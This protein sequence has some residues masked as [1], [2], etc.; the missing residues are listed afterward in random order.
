MKILALLRA[1]RYKQFRATVAP[2][3]E[4]QSV[5]LVTLKSRL[6]DSDA[7]LIVVDPSRM[8][9]E[10]F[11]AL[12]E[13]ANANGNT[14]VL[15]HAPL[16]PETAR[17]VVEASRIQC[18]EVVFFG[19][20][21]ER[22]AL[23]Q[24]CDQLMVPSVPALVLSGLAESLARMPPPLATRVVGQLGGQPFL[25]STS[26]MLNGLG[27]D[28]HTVRRWLTVAGITHPHHLRSSVVLARTF[29]ELARRRQSLAQIVDHFDAGSERGFRR[30]CKTLTRLPPR[31]AGRLDGVDFA[32]RMLS[33]VLDHRDSARTPRRESGRKRS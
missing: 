8:R 19:A 12:M 7:K 20:Y 11:I 28:S 15:V 9:P 24:V 25:R 30:V 16:T 32:A 23:A 2:K 29:P 27:V 33:V 21:D 31:D 18:I 13:T 6:A 10:A 1:D 26:A 3:Y 14:A 17:V 5:D 22:E 4:V